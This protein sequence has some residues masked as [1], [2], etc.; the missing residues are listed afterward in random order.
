M[1]ARTW[2]QGRA[3]MASVD[4]ELDA[5]TLAAAVGAARRRWPIPAL[6]GALLV[7]DPAAGRAVAGERPDLAAEVRQVE[8]LPNGWAVAWFEPPPS[9]AG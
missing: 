6:P 7:D 4:A 5:E 9:G 2:R 1:T 8:N 3:L